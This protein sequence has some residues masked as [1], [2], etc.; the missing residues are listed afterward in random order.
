[1]QRS[2]S[3]SWVGWPADPA[4]CMAA[5]LKYKAALS[6]AYRLCLPEPPHP[7]YKSPY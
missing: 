1:M 4:E 3:G 2:I 7:A 5:K 6:E